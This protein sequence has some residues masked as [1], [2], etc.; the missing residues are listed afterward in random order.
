LSLKV[1]QDDLFIG[2]L[3]V[4]EHLIF[5]AML[6]MGRRVSNDAKL[7]RVEEVLNEVNKNY[8]FKF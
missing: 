3:K 1:Q 7:S 8:L 5:Q 6:R 4:K 2:T